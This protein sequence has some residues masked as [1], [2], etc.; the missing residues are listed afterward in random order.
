MSVQ[1]NNIPVTLILV[2]FPD[3]FTY[4]F[5]LI[6]KDRFTAGERKQFISYLVTHCIQQKL[7]AVYPLARQLKGKGTTPSIPLVYTHTRNSL[8]QPT[9]VISTKAVGYYV[10]LIQ[11]LLNAKVLLYNG[12][13]RSIFLNPDPKA[14]ALGIA[15]LIDEEPAAPSL[16]TTGPIA[17]HQEKTESPVKT[18][19]VRLDDSEDCDLEEALR[20]SLVQFEEEKKKRQKEEEEE[21]LAIEREQR[22]L[23]EKKAEEERRAKELK[24]KAEREERERELREKARRELEEK[25]RKEKE[26]QE[27]ERKEKERQEKEQ[28]EKERLELERR[29]IAEEQARGQWACS[30]C[31]WK[32]SL[33]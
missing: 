13:E 1:I 29:R 9:G 18:T 12:R 14:L 32:I 24:E 22:E 3:N 17:N 15:T 7:P 21:L 23:Q 11:L 25:E 5:F 8:L 16:G 20:L 30:R 19:V 28:A 10:E 27:K 2:S 4:C 26:I 6:D 31:T 33:L